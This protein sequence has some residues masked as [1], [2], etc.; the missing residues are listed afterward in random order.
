[1]GGDGASAR[2]WWVVPPPVLRRPF[3][4]A[5]LFTF[6]AVSILAVVAHDAAMC[7]GLHG[8]DPAVSWAL[9]LPL[10]WP[11]FLW[12]PE[13]PPGAM[14]LAPLWWLAVAWMAARGGIA[15]W[16]KYG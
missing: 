12:G 11:A 13:P 2:G 5:L 6:V 16:L 4:L 14:L 7:P 15:L 8:C 1:M 9:I 10:W 3:F